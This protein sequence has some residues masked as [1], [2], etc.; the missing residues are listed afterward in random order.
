MSNLAALLF[1]LKCLLERSRR[2]GSYSRTIEEKEYLEELRQAAAQLI[3]GD[4]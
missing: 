3:C 4:Y 1:D 2:P